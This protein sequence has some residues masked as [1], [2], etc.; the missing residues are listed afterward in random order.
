M[1]P[2]FLR[3]IIR[4]PCCASDDRR[5]PLSTKLTNEDVEDVIEAVEENIKSNVRRGKYESF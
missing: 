4:M 1:M 2:D 5:L 3:K